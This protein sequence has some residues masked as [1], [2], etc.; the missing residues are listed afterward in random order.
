LGISLIRAAV[1]NFKD[2]VIVSSVEQYSLFLETI[3][4]QN[5]ATTL[6][7]RKLLATSISC[8]FS[9]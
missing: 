3:T 4:K 7:D 8:F 6:E 9:L 1:K 2:T 5:G